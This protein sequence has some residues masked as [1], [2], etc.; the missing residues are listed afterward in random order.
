[1]INIFNTPL[2]RSIVCKKME[3][4]LD[5]F[6]G[7]ILGASGYNRDLVRVI[8]SIFFP[9]SHSLFITRPFDKTIIKN[10]ANASMV[11]KDQ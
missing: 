11:D 9:L 2:L 5:Y 1:M 10:D 7:Y 6:F 8:K 4:V 3:K